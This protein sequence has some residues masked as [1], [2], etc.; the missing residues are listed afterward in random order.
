MIVRDIKKVGEGVLMYTRF[1]PVMRKWKC[2]FVVK[3]G[4]KYT[5]DRIL[6]AN[7]P[8]IYADSINNMTFTYET[9][10]KFYVFTDLSGYT[11]FA[12]YEGTKLH[13]PYPPL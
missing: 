6:L 11:Y 12:D 7:K 8:K 3:Q 5:V 9:T 2:W 4:E 1:I 13:E 10:N